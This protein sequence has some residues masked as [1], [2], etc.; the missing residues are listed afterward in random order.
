[1]SLIILFGLPGTGKTYVGKILEKYYEYCFYDGDNDLTPKMKASIKTQTVFT[2]Q[3][4]DMF[5]EKLTTKI[6]ELRTLQG[7]EGNLKCKN[8]AIAQ[9][10]IKEKYRIELIDKIPEAKFVLIQTKKSI[11][12]K[13]LIERVDYPLNLDYARI[14]EKNFDK[15]IIDYITIIN[16]S[17]GE[18]NI[19][20]Q[21]SNIIGI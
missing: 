10:F 5:F 11:R 21:I 19:K 3:M 8:L 17:D 14:M 15:P 9:T 7:A 16:N 12:E 13:R 6:Q 1:M 18:E 2:D 20:K 4:R